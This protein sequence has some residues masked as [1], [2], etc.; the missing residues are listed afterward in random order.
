MHIVSY[1]NNCENTFNMT[2]E[3][4][5]KDIQTTYIELYNVQLG[6]LTVHTEDGA[7]TAIKKLLLAKCP[8]LSRDI[9]QVQNDTILDLSKYEISIVRCFF[10]YLYADKM[11]LLHMTPKRAV[12]LQLLFEKYELS[13]VDEELNKLSIQYVTEAPFDALV[14]TSK[15]QNKDLFNLA[16]KNIRQLICQTYSSKFHIFKHC[17]DDVLLQIHT[18]TCHQ[19]LTPDKKDS[20]LKELKQLK[21]LPSNLK[22]IVFEDML[23]KEERD[24]RERIKEN[25]KEEQKKLEDEKKKQKDIENEEDDTFVSIDLSEENTDKT[26]LVN[27]KVV[28]PSGDS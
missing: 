5:K 24:E 23:T 9:I 19:I 21:T 2:T 1:Y 28:C 22:S 3:T 17:A 4:V 20:L 7:W 11:E 6:D 13:V 26:I 15:L 27:S 18:C 10:K 25:K 14:L 12:D 8:L 16:L